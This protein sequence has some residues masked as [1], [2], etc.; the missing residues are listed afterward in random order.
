MKTRNTPFRLLSVIAGVTMAFALAYATKPP[1]MSEAPLS[2]SATII[3]SGCSTY[4]NPNPPHYPECC[5][6]WIWKCL[7]TSDTWTQRSGWTFGEACNNDFGYY[8]CPS[9]MGVDPPQ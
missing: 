3:G 1:C 9:W 6:Y 8:V 4:T 7:G 2:C 5:Q